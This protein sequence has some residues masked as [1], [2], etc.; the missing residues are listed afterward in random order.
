MNEAVPGKPPRVSLIHSEYL[1]VILAKHGLLCKEHNW[2]SIGDYVTSDGFWALHTQYMEFIGESN[3]FKKLF[4]Y[5]NESQPDVMRRILL[6]LRSFCDCHESY[7]M[8]EQK[9]RR[10][11]ELVDLF[12]EKMSRD[13]DNNI[14][15]WFDEN[16]R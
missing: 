9:G 1:W 3:E 8:Y 16:L 12:H 10:L 6:W 15:K 14:A 5:L 11:F 13:R 4:M 7:T 2:G